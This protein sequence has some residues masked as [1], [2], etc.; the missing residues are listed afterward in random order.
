MASNF[1]LGNAS[2]LSSNLGSMFGGGTTQGTLPGPFP[3]RPIQ[4]PSDSG[5]TGSGPASQR[6]YNPLGAQAVRPTSFGNFDPQYGQ[7]LATFIGGM[8]QRPQQNQPLQ[9]NPYGNLTDANVQYPQLGGG[10]APGVGLP[11][12]LLQFAQLFNPT[13]LGTNRPVATPSQGNNAETA[14]ERRENRRLS[15]D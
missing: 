13:A 3:A 12:T 10:N 2:D 1:Y 4:G 11:Q 5:M 8:F 15:R 9:F 6:P 14:A 7:N